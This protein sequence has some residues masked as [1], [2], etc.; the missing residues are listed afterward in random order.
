MK[1]VELVVKKD[2]DGAELNWFLNRGYVILDMLELEA[3]QVKYIL[4]Q[5]KTKT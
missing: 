3:D 5:R 2:H 4:E 1:K